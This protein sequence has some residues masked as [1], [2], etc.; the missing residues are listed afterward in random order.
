MSRKSRWHSTVEA[1]RGEV[2]TA[3]DLHNSPTSER[4]L[5]SYLVHMHLAWLYLLQAEFQ[6]NG[7]NYFY[8]DTKTKRYLK[9]DG[10][11][12]AWELER[13]VKVRWPSVADPV[14]Q[15]LELTIKL[16]DKVEHRFEK[17][18][19][20]ASAGFT[21]SLVINYEEELVT[22]F[23]PE[24]SVADRVHLPV[25]LSTFSREG[26]AALAAAQAS[27]PKPLQDFFVD[28]RAGLDESTRSNPAFEFR[29]EIIQKRAPT[30]Q[31]DMA[32]EFVRLDELTPEERQAYEALERTGRIV[33]RDKARDVSNAGWSL[34][35]PT[36]IAIEAQLGLRFSL[37]DFAKA[38][39]YFDVR[40][41]WDKPVND[42]AKTDLLYCRYDTAF[43]AY[44]YSQAFVDLVVEESRTPE[45]YERITGRKPEST[46]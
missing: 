39:K 24:Y 7:I 3:V 28:Y 15:N 16:R 17:G 26:A 23:G 43:G 29:I 22:E 32:V 25:A 9:V 35:K 30:S 21:Q 20:V 5:D 18:L 1:S 38:W 40:P 34:P 44:V 42:R 8:R 6:K 45:G 12:R 27:L 11:R 41:G 31:A 46:I 13:C 19:A 33:L 14:R 2:L 37:T 36:S 10:D 4:P